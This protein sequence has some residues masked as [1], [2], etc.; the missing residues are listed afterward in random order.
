M[1]WGNLKH[2]SFFLKSTLSIDFLLLA[3]HQKTIPEQWIIF[4]EQLG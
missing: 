4:T 3:R 2:A 1:F